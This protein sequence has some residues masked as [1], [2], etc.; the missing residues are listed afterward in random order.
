MH[1]AVA[2]SPAE[3]GVV[4]DHSVAPTPEEDELLPVVADVVM[5]ADIPRIAL[6]RPLG[7]LEEPLVPHRDVVVDLDV[8]SGVFAVR[9]DLDGAAVG[10]PAAPGGDVVFDAVVRDLVVR[11]GHH[12][13]DGAPARV[14]EKAGAI[15]Y[16]VPGDQDMRAIALDT[17][18]IV[19]D[20]VVAND[21]VLGAACDEDRTH[22]SCR[23]HP[24]CGSRTVVEIEAVDNDVA[25]FDQKHIAVEMTRIR[26]GEL[27][28]MSLVTVGRQNNRRILAA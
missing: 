6:C 5:D 8:F 7:D 10:A 11:G 27:G 22:L 28:G 12:D 19:V 23:A 1:V 15:V 14:M 2:W 3:H 18:G 26:A 20:L 17:H 13:S 24:L 9:V 4:L 21:D 25:A 16:V